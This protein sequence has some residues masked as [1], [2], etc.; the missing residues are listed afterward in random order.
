MPDP[1]PRYRAHL[2]ICHG[3]SCS[4]RGRPDEAKKYFKARIKEHG[5][6]Q[7]IRACTSSCL[8]LCDYGPNMVIYPEGTWYSGVKE[9]DWQE[10]FESHLL[11]GR[12][13]ARLRTKFE[14]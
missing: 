9:S 13:V 5:L 8:D 12:P 4:E 7:E 2:F 14:K 3:K 1:D 6:K 10:I 11:K